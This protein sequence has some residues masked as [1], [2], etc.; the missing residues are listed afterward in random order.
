MSSMVENQQRQN[1]SEQRGRGIS[2]GDTSSSSNQVSTSGSTSK[3]WA[4]ELA[5]LFECPVCLEMI[6]P[7]IMQCEKPKE[8][9]VFFPNYITD[10]ENHDIKVTIASIEYYK[11]SLFEKV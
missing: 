9:L 1:V 7:P 5:A 2:S 10:P 3:T 8:F 11:K 6:V 4:D